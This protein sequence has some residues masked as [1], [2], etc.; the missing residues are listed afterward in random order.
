MTAPDR[1]SIGSSTP[2]PPGVPADGA[3]RE[4]IA[5]RSPWRLFRY[6]EGAPDGPPVVIIYSLINRPALLDLDPQRS[7]VRR[8]L[9]QGRDVYL[10]AWDAPARWQRH[11]GLADYA[12]RFPR[13][14]LATVCRRRGVSAVDVIGIC[15]GGV[16]ALCQAAAYPERVRRLV[17]V[18]TPLDPHQ[19][20][21]R[22]LRLARA[23]DPDTLEHNVPGEA[24]STAFTALRPTDLLV[25]R[26]RRSREQSGDARH[27][28]FLRMER[29]MYDCPDQPA[30]MLRETLAWLYRD[31]RLARGCLVLDGRTIDPSA[32][33]AP[34]LTI[35][36]R[37]DHLVPAETALVMARWLSPQQLTEVCEPGGHLGLFVSARA[38]TGLLPGIGRWLDGRDKAFALPRYNS[39]TSRQVPSSHRY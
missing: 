9:E 15:Q 29:W 14:A 13:Q 33:R 11:L 31:N 25:R 38:Q 22:L 35:A 26:Y 20:D 10:L 6:T 28:R 39:R 30:R 8:L 21:H 32:I 3:A 7:L 19:A 5:A 34:V 4:V 18:A 37:R 12:L 1:F 27:R 17:L 16:L 23:T 24:L 2:E 36:A